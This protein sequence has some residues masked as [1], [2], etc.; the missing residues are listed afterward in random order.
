MEQKEDAEYL[1]RDN[2]IRS[3]V[4]PSFSWDVI[5]PR[6]MK[7]IAVAS[8]LDYE[9]LGLSGQALSEIVASVERGELVVRGDLS[10]LPATEPTGERG[11]RFT[12]T[13]IVRS[14]K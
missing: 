4:P 3:F 1:L 13:Q 10:Y 11:V 2:G 14:N 12:I 9:H 8:E 7:T 5:D 6:S